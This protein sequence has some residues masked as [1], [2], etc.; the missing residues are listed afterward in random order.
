MPNRHIK[1]SLNQSLKRKREEL[2]SVKKEIRDAQDQLAD[3][4]QELTHI[5]ET[6]SEETSKYRAMTKS[7]EE[8]ME[9]L[10][11]SVLKKQRLIQKENEQTVAKLIRIKDEVSAMVIDLPKI[12][13]NQCTICYSN[14]ADTCIDPCGHVFCKS[15]SETYNKKT[16][17]C[18]V[19]KGK[20]KKL[21]KVYCS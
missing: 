15:C 2:K 18:M 16:K 12:M 5:K 7:Q 11:S 9:I 10:E 17:K 19:C 8:L 3:L 20:V 1:S 13:T 21:M 6:L 4:Y 14:R